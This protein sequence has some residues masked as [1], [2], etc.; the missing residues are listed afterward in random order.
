MNLNQKFSHLALHYASLQFLTF[1]NLN[2]YTKGYCLDV[3]G[4]KKYI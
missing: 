3:H 1:F 2:L 4:V